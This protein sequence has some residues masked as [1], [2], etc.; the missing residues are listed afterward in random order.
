MALAVVSGSPVGTIKQ[1][2]PSSAY[3][4]IPPLSERTQAAPQAMAS[5]PVRPNP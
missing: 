5:T 1:L 3:C 4:E 2:V